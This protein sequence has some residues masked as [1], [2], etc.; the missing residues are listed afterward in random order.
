MRYLL[1]INSDYQETEAKAAV[2]Q[3]EIG[4]WVERMDGRSVRRFGH[5]LD[6]PANAVTVRVRAGETLLTDGPFAETK[7]W[8]GGINIVDCE[9]LDEAIEVAATHPVSWFHSIEVRPFRGEAFEPVPEFGEPAAGHERYLLQMCLD[10]IP[11][12]DAV[13]EQLVRESRAWPQR[14]GERLLYGHPLAPADSATTV[15]VRDGETL[16]SDGPFAET[17]EYIGGFAILETA[18]RQEAIELA[19]A[20]P[21]AA[22]HCVEV[23]RLA[24]L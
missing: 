7:E 4:P 5:P 10:G 20:H 2:M 18:S 19:A 11:A 16:L 14:A 21:L 22:H 3:R 23:R 17:K 12:P 8:I 24:V 6:E 1:F 15:R 13:E 9:D